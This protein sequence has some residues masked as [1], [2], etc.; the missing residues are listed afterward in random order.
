[1]MAVR[2]ARA[3]L[4]IGAVTCILVAVAGLAALRRLPSRPARARESAEP[5][6]AGS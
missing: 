4:G 1:V 5:V 6:A 2:G 3:G